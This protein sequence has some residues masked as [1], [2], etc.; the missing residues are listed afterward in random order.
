ML[1]IVDIFSVTELGNLLEVNVVIDSFSPSN[2]DV[3]E[4]LFVDVG[5]AIVGVS[6]SV[7][8]VRAKSRSF[9]F[10][11]MSFREGIVENFVDGM[12]SVAS[13]CSFEVSSADVE[14]NEMTLSF[15]S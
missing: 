12:V 2:F 10:D 15:S 3:E 13:V 14:E 9:S 6:S 8:P 11:K 7:S 4:V 1:D 5:G